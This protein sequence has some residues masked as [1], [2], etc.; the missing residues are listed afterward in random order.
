MQGTAKLPEP[1]ASLSSLPLELKQ[2]IFSLLWASD[3]P[4]AVHIYPQTCNASF[5]SLLRLAQVNRVLHSDVDAF[6]EDIL[7]TLELH[8]LCWAGGR[9]VGPGRRHH[10]M[11][12]PEQ[13]LAAEA[14]GLDEALQS[15]S[16]SPSRRRRGAIDLGIPRRLPQRWLDHV[17]E[18]QIEA[19]D[20]HHHLRPPLDVSARTL[21][22]LKTL[23]I[24][25]PGITQSC[26]G[27]NTGVVV[28]ESFAELE[29]RDSWQ[30]PS[31]AW[32][33]DLA[34]QD[35]PFRILHDIIVAC[36]DGRHRRPYQWC[37]YTFEFQGRSSSSRNTTVR[38]TWK[39][40]G[41]RL[42]TTTINPD[43][44]PLKGSKN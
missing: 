32:V 5:G 39:R 41:T 29:I 33:R 12:G 19:G 21:P 14:S 24:F 9:P 7:P 40:L 8:L 43:Y 31:A 28:A 6:L 17:L 34:L 2:Q 18:V 35:P 11:A 15:C 30:Q 23:R 13:C 27:H 44:L 1:A 16:I 42:I 10:F 3:K 4:V 36:E 26:R 20:I 22:A 38:P 37:R 25:W